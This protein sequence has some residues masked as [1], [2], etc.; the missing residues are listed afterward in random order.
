MLGSQAIGKL[1]RYRVVSIVA[2]L[3][4]SIGSFLITLM[5]PTTGIAPAISILVLTSIGIGP[6]SS[7]PM[8]VVQNALPDRKMKI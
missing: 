2:V 7:L 6:F 8:L 5:M 3:L 4:M 1:K